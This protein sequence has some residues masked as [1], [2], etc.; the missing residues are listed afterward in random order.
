MRTVTL[1]LLLLLAAPL[2]LASAQAAEMTATQREAAE[3][4]AQGHFQAGS[5]Y[6]SSGDY[7]NA[8]TEFEAAYADSGRARLRYNIFLCQ[9]RLGQLPAAIASLE[10][11]LASAGEIEDRD[12][13]TE[14]LGHLRERQERAAATVP[15]DPQQTRAPDSRAPDPAALQP[16]DTTDRGAGPAVA[17]AGFSVAAAGLISFGIF[18]GLTLS[19]DGRLDSC[20][21]TCTASQTDAIGTYTLLSDIGAA[22]ALTGAIVGI[23]GLL[24][25]APKS[26]STARVRLSP[27]GVGYLVEF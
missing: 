11:Y 9:E 17:I 16:V 25:P 15:S 4:R 21:P 10:S 24:L 27:A 6:F 5:L 26:S 20:S 12:A 8:L 7:E 2:G 3:A 19:E 1:A 13:L 14:R 23:I 18:G 22:V